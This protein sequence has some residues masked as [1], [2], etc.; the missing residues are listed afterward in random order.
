MKVLVNVTELIKIRPNTNYLQT[1]LVLNDGDETWP[2]GCYLHLVSPTEKSR[3]PVKRVKPG[4]SM[5]IDVWLMSPLEVGVHQNKWRLST[6]CGMFYGDT[7]WA[8]VEVDENAPEIRPA[9]TTAQT[10]EIEERLQNLWANETRPGET[11]MDLVPHQS[12][13]GQWPNIPAPQGIS[14]PPPPPGP[15]SEDTEM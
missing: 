4:E 5:R 9:D 1:W 13:F 10:K 7:L 12:N 15:S 11:R 8:M 14:L 3:V 6:P 2:D